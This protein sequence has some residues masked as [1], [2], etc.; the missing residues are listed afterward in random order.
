MSIPLVHCKPLDERMAHDRLEHFN[1]ENPHTD[2]HVKV[3]GKCL[4]LIKVCGLKRRV[5]RSKRKAVT[6]FSPSARFR[7]LQMAASVDWE[8]T[9]DCTFITLTYPDPKVHY[10]PKKRTQERSRFIRDLEQHSGRPLSCL[11]RT[12][13]KPRL[14][15]QLE[16][17]M[18]P[19]IHLLVLCRVPGGRK[20]VE[21]TWA[22]AIGWH[23]WLSVDF[24]VLEAGQKAS[25]YVSK[26]VG[27]C[28]RATSLDNLSYLNK[29]GRHWG[30]T[31]KGLILWGSRWHVLRLSNDELR[32]L[33][34]VA[35]AMLPWYDLSLHE[36][37]TLIGEGAVK[38]IE[39][40]VADMVAKREKDHA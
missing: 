28:D 21:A 37:F 11:W 10:D 34:T 33:R 35:A 13:W 27:K 4:K 39:G 5:V 32:R 8:T 20:W 29:T 18:C 38:V 23:E 30:V 40:I 9:G 3:V 14:S 17:K 25:V 26:Y 2:F 6:V 7:M 19:H 22:K 16:G 1:R 36:G 12:E 24:Q 15:G 31:R